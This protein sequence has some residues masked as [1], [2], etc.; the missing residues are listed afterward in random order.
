MANRAVRHLIALCLALASSLIVA[1]A[2]DEVPPVGHRFG[3]GVIAGANF[4]QVDG[5][6]YGGYNALGGLGGL[7]LSRQFGLSNWG[8][9]VELSY[10]GKGSRSVGLFGGKQ[11][12]RATSYSFTL[13]YLEL[14][15]YAEYVFLNQFAADVGIGA[16]Y[17]LGWAE[18]NA[19]G[20]FDNETRLA[21]RRFELSLHLSLGWQFHRHWGVRGGFAYSILPIRGAPDKLM[22]QRQGQYNNMLYLLFEYEI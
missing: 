5:D 15:I 8:L 17:L 22:G 12:V 13:H 1:S 7:W 16:S 20:D 14:P 6:G 4:S 9:R 19:Y 2:Q 11:G 3:G 18:R 10:V 21:P